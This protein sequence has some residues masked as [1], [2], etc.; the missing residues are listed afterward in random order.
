MEK[1]GA[2]LV[3]EVLL[4][5]AGEGLLGNLVKLLLG[6]TDVFLALAQVAEAPLVLVVDFAYDWELHVI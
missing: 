6:W 4:V 2:E 3:G 5:A 1:V